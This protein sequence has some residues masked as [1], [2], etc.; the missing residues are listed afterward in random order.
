[1]VCKEKGRPVEGGLIMGDCN[2]EVEDIG[3]NP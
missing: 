1:M 2:G 3:V